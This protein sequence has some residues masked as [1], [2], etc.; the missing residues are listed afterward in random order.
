MSIFVNPVLPLPEYRW[1]FDAI[2][3]DNENIINS[4]MNGNIQSHL[5]L[6]GRFIH[7]HT[8][9]DIVSNRDVPKHEKMYTQT[10]DKTYPWCLAGAHGSKAAL[11]IFINSG[12]NIHQNDN[13]GNIIHCM[14]L[15]AYLNTEKEDL[16]IET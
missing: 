12:V 11:E 13:Q 10:N 9:K 4:P 14:I 8:S 5:L 16:M 1:W 3:T 7:E 2:I 6:N 15:R